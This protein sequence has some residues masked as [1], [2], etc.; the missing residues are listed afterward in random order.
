MFAG[1]FYSYFAGVCTSGLYYKYLYS[2]NFEAK[3]Q[4][5]KEA[6]PS[7]PQISNFLIYS[8]SCTTGFALGVL[9]SKKII[10]MLSKI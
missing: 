9:L 4:L 7:T 10:N 3:K 5:E 2:N 1:I 6:D 8:G